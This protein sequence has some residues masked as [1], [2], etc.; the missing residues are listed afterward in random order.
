MDSGVRNHKFN[1]LVIGDTMTGKSALVQR[2]ISG[3]FKHECDSTIGVEYEGKC[4]LGKNGTANL[5]MAIWDMAGQRV[6]RNLINR[7]YKGGDAVIIVVDLSRIST[8]ESL[9]FWIKETDCLF[10]RHVPYVIVGNKID[11]AKKRRQ[12]SDEDIFEFIGKHT[13]M[14]YIKASALS[15][16]NVNKV[17]DDLVLR[18]LH[19]MGSSGVDGVGGVGGVDGVGVGVDSVDGVD[20]ELN[21]F[22]KLELELRKKRER[23]WCGLRRFACCFSN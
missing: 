2:Y 14:E 18:I 9:E 7:Y 20:K 1:I 3:S 10:D 4:I 5:R 23:R 21:D 19:N 12:V 22:K 15:G 13:N 8:F 11:L 17:F 16:K 6:F